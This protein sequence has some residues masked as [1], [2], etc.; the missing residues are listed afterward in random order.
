MWIPAPYGTYA[1]KRM[2]RPC[3]LEVGACII[4]YKPFVKGVL[5]TITETPCLVTAGNMTRGQAKQ[6]GYKYVQHALAAL[7]A[8]HGPVTDDSEFWAIRFDIGDSSDL[9]DK[10]AE[11]YL[12]AK[13]VGITLNPDKGVF[14]EGA[15]PSA[16][17][18]E[19]ANNARINRAA[20]AQ[21]SIE[22]A[23]INI[24]SELEKIR[25]HK[26]ELCE[27]ARKDVDFLERRAQRLRKR[28]LEPA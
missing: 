11:R 28:A 20:E 2:P 22:N 1:G 6:Q 19:Y 15:V 14:G 12:K 27:G 25:T 18:L 16:V 13:G 5:I 10:H 9:W 26:G 3:T 7:S 4:L 21:R 23:L 17:D 8:A 24:E